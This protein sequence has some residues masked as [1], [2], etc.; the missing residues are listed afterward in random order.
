MVSKLVLGTVQF[1][2]KYGINHTQKPSLSQ[3]HN[4]MREAQKQG[5]AEIDT[6]AAYGNALEIIAEFNKPIKIITKVVLETDDFLAQLKENL[7][8]LR[9]NTVEGC[10]LHR[11]SDF[12]RSNLFSGLKQAKEQGFLK[13]F[14]VSIYSTEELETVKNHPEVDIIQIPFNIFDQD[15]KKIK[16]LSD[17]RKNGKVIYA[18][19]VFLQGLFFM[20]PERLPEKLKELSKPLN[21]LQQLVLDYKMDLNALCLKYVLDM[22]CIDKI[23]I[24]VENEKQLLENV[25]ASDLDIPFKLKEKLQQLNVVNKNLVNPLLW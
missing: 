13:K 7:K 1:G 24:G 17:A 14:G 22:E 9:M 18:R 20:P 8:R 2:L 6:A 19:S 5:I 16:I 11:F 10:Y 4:I 25:K 3:A 21:R 23:I 15:E 12:T